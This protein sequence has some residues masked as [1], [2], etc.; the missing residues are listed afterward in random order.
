[1]SIWSRVS[2]FLGRKAT[3][4]KGFLETPEWLRKETDRQVR[5]TIAVIALGAKLAK[6]DG[7]V[8]VDEVRVFR[9]IFRIDAADEKHAALVY[10]Y[11]RQSPAGYESYGRSVAAL[12]PNN[13]RILGGVL[14]GLFHVAVADGNLTQSEVEFLYRINELFGFSEEYFEGLLCRFSDDPEADPYRVLGVS[15][16][17]P[18][19][20]IRLRWRSLVRQYHPDVLVGDGIPHEAMKLAES[21]LASYNDAWAKIRSMHQEATSPG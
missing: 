5:F 12:F 10:N 11:A 21:R 20:E 6:V 1:M 8:T 19:D 17:T 16:D 7:T 18:V 3:S 2:D 4:G 13:R 15:P 9:E 14:D